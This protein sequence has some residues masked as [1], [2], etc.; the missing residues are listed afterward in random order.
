[1]HHSFCFWI[2]KLG[3]TFYLVLIHL[4]LLVKQLQDNLRQVFGVCGPITKVFLHKK[5]ATKVIQKEK[6]DLFAEK[7]TC[8]VST[9]YII[10][11]FQYTLIM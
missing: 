6:S 7:Q 5:P 4:V 8:K 10:K 9:K 1:M 3:H 2:L 11:M